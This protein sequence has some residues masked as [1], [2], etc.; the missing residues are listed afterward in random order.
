MDTLAAHNYTY[1][2]NIYMEMTEM[3]SGEEV[4]IV[5]ENNQPVSMDLILDDEALLVEST[6]DLLGCYVTW[7][8]LSPGISQW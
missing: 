1:C 5:I 3:H 2:E 8:E 6:T 7:S 4:E